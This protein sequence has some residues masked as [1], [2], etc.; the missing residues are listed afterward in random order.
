MIAALQKIYLIKWNLH[1]TQ[2]TVGLFSCNKS[3][4]A[5]EVLE[6]KIYKSAKI[7]KF[8]MSKGHSNRKEHLAILLRPSRYFRKV[9]KPINEWWIIDKLDIFTRKPP[10]SKLETEKPQGDEATAYL[11]EQMELEGRSEAE[12]ALH[13]AHINDGITVRA[14]RGRRGVR[15]RGERERERA[16]REPGESEGRESEER[17]S[18]ERESE[19]DEWGFWAR[20]K[21]K[22][23]N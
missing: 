19:E 10:S 14:R 16:R 2:A 4:E 8:H 6:K 11:I 12:I 7:S 15:E 13:L 1:K 22:R 9:T 20:N 5:I 21:V 18:E 17:E 3:L 23:D